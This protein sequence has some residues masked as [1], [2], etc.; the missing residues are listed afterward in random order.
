MISNGIGTNNQNHVAPEIVTD[1][2]AASSNTSITS[3]NCNIQLYTT[4]PFVGFS[5]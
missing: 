2:A 4:I 1:D 3:Q 5:C